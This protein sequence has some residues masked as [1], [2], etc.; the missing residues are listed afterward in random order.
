M[1]G[2]DRKRPHNGRSYPPPSK[3]HLSKKP[4]APLPASRSPPQKSPNQG[5][6]V[7]NPSRPGFASY[8]ET[9]NLP[10]KI[11]I[12]CEIIATTHSLSTE[13]VLDDSIAG[14]RVTQ[15]DVEEVLK[16]SYGFPGPAVK[17]FRWS[18]RLLCG[19]HSPYAWNLV[20]DM[21]G[22]NSL[23]DAM[24]DAIKSMHTEGLL[25]LATFASVFS[26]YVTA[27]KVHDAI[28]AFDVMDQYGVAQDIVALNSLLSAI[29]WEGKVMDAVEFLQVAKHRIEPDLDTYAI[30][31]EGCEKERNADVAKSVFSDM[32]AEFGWDPRN[33][34]AYNSLLTTLVRVPHGAREA[35][36]YF[37]MMGEHRCYPGTRFLREAFDECLKRSDYKEAEHFW[38]AVVER[39]GLRPDTE[40]YNSM[41]ALYC[42]NNQHELAIRLLD[43]MACNGAFPNEE[44]YNVLLKFLIKG[45]RLVDASAIF[46][47]MIKNEFMPSLVNCQAAVR[48]FLDSGNSTMALKVWR[49]MAERYEEELEDT[50]NLLIV[51]LQ[52]LNRLPEAVKYAVDII[53]RKIK[54]DSSTLSKLKQSLS[55]AG[56]NQMYSEILQKWKFR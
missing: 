26:S 9:P 18:G 4:R 27:G 48:V 19:D 10:P 28:M 2:N 50:A 49:W 25:S 11:K 20:V 36:K 34:P 13:R 46:T 43:E 44:T 15:E 5:L 52:D 55:K 14:L 17:F 6:G 33:L 22:K 21:L 41:I 16:V 30:L 7:P 12:I 32:V 39:A 53:E 35:V 37:K 8:L 51:G 56:K 1:R 38:E 29:C 24:W 45:R 42:Y 47:E 3:P 54:L 40:M 23:F 31:L